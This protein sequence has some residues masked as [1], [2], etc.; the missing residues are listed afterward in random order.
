MSCLSPQNQNNSWPGYW[1]CLLA[2]CLQPWRRDSQIETGGGLREVLTPGRAWG[3]AP[4]TPGRRSPAA[5]GGCSAGLIS[6]PP[7]SLG[8]GNIDRIQIQGFR[9]FQGRV[10]GGLGA[11]KILAF[12]G[13]NIAIFIHRHPFIHFHPLLSISIIC[14]HFCGHL[15]QSVLWP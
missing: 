6:G 14:Y 8:A 15:G 10:E 13:K 1:K 12:S 7:P 2:C 9:G 4:R 5:R 11:F 3:E